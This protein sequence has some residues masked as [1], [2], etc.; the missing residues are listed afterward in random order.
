M[1]D[2]FEKTSPPK[3]SYRVFLWSDCMSPVSHMQENSGNEGVLAREPVNTLAGKRRIPFLSGNAFRH[4]M[5]REPG[6]LW[7]IEQLGLKGK[8]S[9]EQLNFLIHGGNLTESTAREDTARIAEMQEIFPFLRLL[10]GALPNQML[11]G[12]LI[13]WRGQLLCSEN[14]PFIL[15][16]HGWSLPNTLKS[17]EH[18]VES[19]QYTRND[20]RQR[21]EYYDNSTYTQA[22]ESEDNETNQM[23]MGGQTVIKGGVYC[24]GFDLPYS[25][26]LEYGCLMHAMNIWQMNGG[27]I[28]GQ[29]SKGHGRLYTQIMG[30]DYEADRCIALYEAHVE[31]NKERCV[32]WLNKVFNRGTE[33]KPKKQKKGA[34]TK[35]KNQDFVT[36]GH[37][38]YED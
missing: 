30:E 13:M 20:A 17:A 11:K 26:E 12:S 9:L 2:L 37:E 1:S 16:P 35:A 8:L 14:V 5:I 36:E 28:G 31:E 29:A 33:P 27:T 22:K 38:G 15:L 24:H 18:Y 25:S 21:T 32:T 19:F 23:I 3:K 34:K 4:R 7:L 6:G 10:G